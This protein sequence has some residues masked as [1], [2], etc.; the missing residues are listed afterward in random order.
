ML[1]FREIVIRADVK[2][3]PISTDQ[4]GRDYSF[5]HFLGEWVVG[6][7]GMRRD[8]NLP[9]LFEWEEAIE[10][11]ATRMAT[12][13]GVVEPVLPD[14]L[15]PPELRAGKENEE[16]NA[17]LSREFAKTVQA[18]Q[19]QHNDER[20][21]YRKAIAKASVGENMYVSDEAFLAAKAACK[22][23]IDLASAP[24]PTGRRILH[25]AYEAKVL[26]HYHALTMSKAIEERDVP[27][28]RAI[29]VSVEN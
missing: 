24:D 18:A 21:A 26:R 29:S 15:E 17:A 8:E 27:T 19:K 2:M 23:F 6:A 13:A 25:A 1:K 10:G 9:H 22:D 7:R 28:S 5:L 14:K 11:F 4:P 20:D 3:P 16:S 12:K